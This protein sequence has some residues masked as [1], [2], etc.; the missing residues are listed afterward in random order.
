MGFQKFK[1]PI[2]ARTKSDPDFLFDTLRQTVTV[3]TAASTALGPRGVFALETT[4]TGAPVVYDIP[5]PK[6]GDQISLMV[7]A[8]QSSSDAPFHINL[9]TL[10]GPSTGDDMV[11][12]STQGAGI[13][14]I[15]ISTSRW[16]TDGNQGATFSTST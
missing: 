14:L 5:A 13:S 2:D 8:M 15:A 1:R 10:T 3:S 12:L 9:G 7:S 6:V 11:L 4:S 16:L